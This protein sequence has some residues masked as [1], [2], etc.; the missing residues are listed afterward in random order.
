MRQSRAV[1]RL[2]SRQRRVKFGPFRGRWRRLRSGR[3][4]IPAGQIGIV[5]R[6]AIGIVALI[7]ALIHWGCPGPEEPT[8]ECASFPCRKQDFASGY[9][10]GVRK[11]STPGSCEYTPE[12]PHRRH[13]FPAAGTTWNP[14]NPVSNRPAVSSAKLAV[15]LQNSDEKS[16]FVSPPE[17]RGLGSDRRSDLHH[18]IAVEPAEEVIVALDFGWHSDSPLR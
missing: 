18:G 16:R 10:W 12:S 17:N 6:R 14:L 2:F 1:G 7:I 3:S 9:R 15:C 11:P 4:P 13:R 8:R 5:P